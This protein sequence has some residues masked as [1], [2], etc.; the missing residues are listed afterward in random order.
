M[1]SKKEKLGENTHPPTPKHNI[2]TPFVLC[3]QL[4]LSVSYF[5]FLYST[6]FRPLLL[7]YPKHKQ[8]EKKRDMWRESENPWDNHH[9]IY[10]F[11]LIHIFRC[12]VV[13]SFFLSF[14]GSHFPITGRNGYG[15]L[16][17][18]RER[19][20]E[21][22]KTREQKKKKKKQFVREDISWD[23]GMEKCTRERERERE[24]ERGEK[25][26]TLWQLHSWSRV[27]NAIAY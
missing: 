11:S 21:G 8:Q 2:L 18:E 6:K 20:R 1:R 13:F 24:R 16:G 25:T 23:C 4:P 14:S 27:S 9:S 17:W 15:E 12:S 19:E 22:A 3:S 5:T 26:N 7:F 10:L